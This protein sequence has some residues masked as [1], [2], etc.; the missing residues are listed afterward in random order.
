MVLA[1]HR[2][3]LFEG[4][5]ERHIDLVFRVAMAWCRS[6]AEAED[7]TQT[8]FLKAYRAFDRFAPG[9][10]FKA[11]VLRI[12]RNAYVDTLRVS[13]AAPVT[14]SLQRAE[15][16][17]HLEAPVPAPVAI[18]FENKEIFYEVF[19][20]EIARLLRELPSDHQLAVLLFDVEGLSYAE[21]ADVLGCPVGTVRSRIHRGR[22]RLGVLLRSYAAQVG[23]LRERHS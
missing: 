22:A 4:L 21:I 7:L 6:A 18:D 5:V 12:L 1:T 17:E 20:D 16:A 8:A 19:G 3:L 9:T 2:D 13:S 23:Y 10:N 15:A 14:H 11:W